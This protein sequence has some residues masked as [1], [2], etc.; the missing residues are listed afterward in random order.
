MQYRSDLPRWL[1]VGLRLL[2]VKSSG[3]AMAWQKIVGEQVD[4]P[5]VFNRFMRL[6]E[7]LQK[8]YS[9]QLEPN[10]NFRAGSAVMLE[11]VQLH[12]LSPEHAQE[13]YQD[14]FGGRV[15]VRKLRDR[16]AAIRQ[17][18][19]SATGTVARNKSQRYAEFSKHAIQLLQT[20]PGLLRL[21]TFRTIEES[22]IRSTLMPKLVAQIREG[23]VAVDVRSPDISAAR[24][25]ASAAAL[26]V[27]RI[28]VLLLRFD[29]VVIVL[30]KSAE[31]YAIEARKL[32]IEWAREGQ[33]IS[34]QVSFLLLDGDD[35]QLLK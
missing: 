2:E 13:L 24:S 22:D 5:Q 10:V 14:V 28:A 32:L 8:H 33:K 15:S 9:D 4:T 21:S 19:E 26:F 11:F 25:T 16:M 23:A 35:A 18:A 6:A 31:T 34:K 30:P 27:S 3:D 12:E 20:Q 7:F 1:A 17:N 29:R